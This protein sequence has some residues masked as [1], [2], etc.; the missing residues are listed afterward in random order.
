[1]TGSRSQAHATGSHRAEG[2]TTFSVDLL[3]DL[4]IQITPGQQLLEPAILDLQVL[5]AIDIG[6]LNLARVLAR[7]IV[8]SSLTLCFLAA[9][10][11]DD[12]I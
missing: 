8:V 12:L 9:S 11:D 7:G 1:M 5:E 4:R 2:I 3:E 6:C 10:S